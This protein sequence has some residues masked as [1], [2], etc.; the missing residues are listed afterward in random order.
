VPNYFL[1][2]LT[3][4][5]IIFHSAI[6]LKSVSDRNLPISAAVININGIPTNANITEN[7]F[8]TSV[9]TETSEYPEN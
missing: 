8:P 1:F 6:I 5:V 7:I 2:T 4:L 3:L 9:F